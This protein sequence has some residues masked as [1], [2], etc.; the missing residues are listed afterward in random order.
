MDSGK[1]HLGECVV[2]F[3][4]AGKNFTAVIGKRSPDGAN[5]VFETFLALQLDAE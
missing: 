5:V 2:S 3:C 1:T 4:N